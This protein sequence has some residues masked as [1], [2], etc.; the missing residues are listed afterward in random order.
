VKL[1]LRL[2]HVKLC[3][4]LHLKVEAIVVKLWIYSISVTM[5]VETVSPNLRNKTTQVVLLTL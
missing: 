4:L 3:E 2:Y 5:N 1:E